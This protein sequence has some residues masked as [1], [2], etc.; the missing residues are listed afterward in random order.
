M[1]GEC[2][3]A[4]ICQRK[5]FC[6]ALVFPR[7]FLFGRNSLHDVK[8]HVYVCVVTVYGCGVVVVYNLRTSLFFGESGDWFG[9]ASWHGAATRLVRM[10][11]RLRLQGV[12]R[13]LGWVVRN[14][15]ERLEF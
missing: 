2:M 15:D 10:A 13:L 7:F 6:L 8:Y 12:A 1:Q 3:A 5:L 11:W 14:N 9:L 4:L